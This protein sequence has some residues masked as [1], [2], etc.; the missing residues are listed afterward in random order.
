[1]SITAYGKPAVMDQIVAQLAKLVDVIHV[2][3]VEL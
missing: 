3:E 2:E 1:M